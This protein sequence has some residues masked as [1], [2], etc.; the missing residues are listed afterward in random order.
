MLKFLSGLIGRSTKNTVVFGMRNRSTALEKKI[1]LNRANR[2]RR[3]NQFLASASEEEKDEFV[4]DMHKL[5]SMLTHYVTVSERLLIFIDNN[6]IQDILK[7]DS[8]RKRMQRFH[9]FLAVL[10]LAQDYYLVDIFACVTPAILYEAGGKSCKHTILET[11]NIFLE[12]ENA[13]AEAGLP[14]HRAGFNKPRQLRTI[15]KQI[16]FDEKVIRAALDKA[17]GKSWK[18]EFSQPGRGTRI[19]FSVAE[20]ECP[21]MR[22]KYFNPGVVKLLFMHLIERQMYQENVDQPKARRM[23]YK[24]SKAFFIIKK[25]KT[26]IEGLGDIELLTHC[27]LSSQTMHNAP[28]ITMGFTYDDNLHATLLNRS[29]VISQGS[30]F[31]G[32]IDSAEDFSLSLVASIQHSNKRTSKANKRIREYATAMNEFYDEVLKENLA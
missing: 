12:V 30:I 17:K 29:T 31:E 5:E 26:G 9:S 6:V 23:M 16:A 1:E 11:E 4:K 32:G 24:F 22:L 15:F 27:D 7:Q 18:R 14:T 21:M 20:E 8:D 19:P 13:I 25:K 2:S 3:I 28:D 10:S